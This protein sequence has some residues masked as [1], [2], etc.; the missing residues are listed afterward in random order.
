MKT[1]AVILCGGS[2]SRLWP[3]SRQSEPKQF[4]AFADGQSLLAETVLRADALPFVDEILIVSSTAYQHLLPAHVKPF[5][6][7]PIHY[8]LE[9]IARNTAGAIASAA[10]YAMHHMAASD[11]SC[12][13]VMP[14]DHHITD[15]SAFQQS[16]QKA[17]LGAQT[18][19]LLTFGV[20]P[21]SPETGYG[22]IEKGAQ[23]AETDCHEVVRFVEKPLLAKAKE[24]I[25]NPNFAWNSG[26][27]VFQAKTLLEE[28]HQFEPQIYQQSLAAI[29]QGEKQHAF[30]TLDLKSLETCPSK[31]I[32]YAVFERSKKIAVATMSASWSDLGSWG[33]VSDLAKGKSSSASS[34]P[35]INI[36]AH[37]N[38]VQA[39]KTVAIVGLSDI[40]VVDTPDALLVS[41][42]E[43][44]QSVKKVVDQLNQQQP[45]LVETHAKVR[46]PWGTYESMHQS[47][48]H[49]VKYIVVEPG[50]R[51]S[52]QSHEH[53]AEH[54]VVVAGQATIT[55]GETCATYSPGQHVYIQKQEKHRLENHSTEP[56]AIIEVQ[57]GNYLGEDDIKRFDDVY[58]RV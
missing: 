9:P 27:F 45:H 29:E 23:L 35:V 49:Q 13:V 46:R 28:T 30:F 48:A 40:V 56:V 24:M 20:V 37:D 47:A 53:R 36:D 6:A 34:S 41:H 15:A 19:R 2:G 51:L 16:I 14:S 8:L 17:M 21:T 10:H 50:G 32:D 38:F 55:V 5:T 12:L 58:G 11:A 57:I 43:H 54:W 25:A 4:H 1:I 31:S 3:L 18:G 26:I 44:S 42:K 33:A 22:Y 39:N 52:L 7:K